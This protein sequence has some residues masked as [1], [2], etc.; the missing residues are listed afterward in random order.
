MFGECTFQNNFRRVHGTISLTSEEAVG[1]GLFIGWIVGL[2]AVIVGYCHNYYTVASIGAVLISYLIYFAI[3]RPIRILHGFSSIIT[4]YC[5]SEAFLDR[6]NV[7]PESRILEDPKFVAQVMK[8]LEI[9]LAKNDQGNKFR[10]TKDT[11][12]AKENAYIGRDVD[13]KA[14]R[15][16]RISPVKIGDEFPQDAIDQFP[17]MVNALR[18]MPNVKSC[19]LSILDP[20]TEIPMHTGYFKGILRYM[21]PLKIPK[22]TDK[23]FLCVNGIKY[24]W[25]EGEGVMWDDMFPHRVENRTNEKRIL[26]YMDIVR[27]GLPFPL[28][29]I[30]DFALWATINNPVVQDELKRSEKKKKISTNDPVTSN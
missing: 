6:F 15:G 23:C 2:I 9:V 28:T 24:S 13:E 17:T 10:F 19:V 5:R 25:K 21:L 18:D 26:F 7:F 14:N 30:Q 3:S 8:E 22:D 20:N 29:L 27:P 16:W 12:D 4:L 1:L 11:F